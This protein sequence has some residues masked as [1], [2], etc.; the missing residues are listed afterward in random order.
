[1]HVVYLLSTLHSDNLG[2]SVE[3]QMTTVLL[4]VMLGT[5]TC[6]NWNMY[7]YV[8]PAFQQRICHFTHAQIYLYMSVSHKAFNKFGY[9]LAR[10]TQHNIIFIFWAQICTTGKG[11]CPLYPALV[12]VEK[13]RQLLPAHIPVPV[14]A[15]KCFYWCDKTLPLNDAVCCNV[16][17]CH[18]ATT[19]IQLPLCIPP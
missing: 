10:S 4:L 12:N 3:Q 7:L 16:V 11:L 9:Q 15:A 18:A 2:N 1:M 13:D 6:H 14:V 8:W 17:F 5:F 19:S